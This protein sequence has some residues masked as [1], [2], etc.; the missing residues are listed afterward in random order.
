[1][2]LTQFDNNNLIRLYS[3]LIKELK[4][5]KII[6][7]SNVLGDLGE[8]LAIDFYSSNPDLPNL[9]AASICAK[10]IDATSEVNGRYSIKSCRTK[11]T[12]IF[13]GLQPEGSKEPDEKTFDYVIICTF[14]NNFEL[15]HILELTW[16][17]FLLH[18]H[19]HKRMNAWNLLLNKKTI[20]DCKIIL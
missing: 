19:W 16:D 15:Q 1:M 17:K 2:N 3:D 7:T 4:Q 13:Y 6:R 11:T 18:K 14:N 12:G 5:R 8:Y 9:K 20:A 10:N